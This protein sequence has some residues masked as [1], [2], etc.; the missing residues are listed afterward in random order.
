MQLL[1]SLYAREGIWRE[2]F[3]DL[4]QDDAF[5]FTR[6]YLSIVLI[7]WV[8]LFFFERLD[9]SV[10][11]SELSL[12]N[13]I[14]HLICKLN[15]ILFQK[16]HCIYRL[17]NGFEQYLFNCLFKH[18]TRY[19]LFEL[20]SHQFVRHTPNLRVNEPAQHHFGVVCH[21]LLAQSWLLSPFLAST[22]CWI[23]GSL[24]ERL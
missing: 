16:V 14:E 7:V 24:K 13:A 21:F 15:G 22:C 3:L 8:L 1:I 12:N 4:I 20:R 10:N 2:A 6:S 23:R 19:F 17:L 5:I 18:S 11:L 9:L